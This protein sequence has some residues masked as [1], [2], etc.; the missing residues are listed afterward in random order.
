MAPKTFVIQ[1]QATKLNSGND[2]SWHELADKHYNLFV[3]LFLNTCKLIWRNFEYL[4]WLD[5]SFF[6]LYQLLLHAWF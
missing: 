3:A 1:T 5:L 2:T 6:N 4:T